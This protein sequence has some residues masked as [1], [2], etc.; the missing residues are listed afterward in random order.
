MPKDSHFALALQEIVEKRPNQGLF[1]R[2]FA[3]T[4][5]DESKTKAE[6]IK[7][8][9]EQIEEQEV[10]L[11][12]QLEE[13]KRR[14]EQAVKESFSYE[15]FAKEY[16]GEIPLMYYNYQQRRAIYKEWYKRK[17]EPN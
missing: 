2:C 6:Y 9:A 10:F 5:G 11:E 16:K 1:A 17:T 14:K 13:D 4:K 12:R 7:K 8:R 15:V 3:E